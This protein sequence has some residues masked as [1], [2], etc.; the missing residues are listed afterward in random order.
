[1]TRGWKASTWEALSQE[2]AASLKWTW[3]P[4]MWH[5]SALPTADKRRSVISAPATDD[6]RP[7]EALFPF[8]EMASNVVDPALEFGA[9]QTERSDQDFKQRFQQG[10][11]DSFYGQGAFY[12]P[13]PPQTQNGSQP[14]ADSADAALQAIATAAQDRRPSTPSSAS[15]GAADANAH[16]CVLALLTLVLP[17]FC[18]LRVL[19]PAEAS[20][21]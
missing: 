12:G 15:V 11:Q 2:N 9:Q 16:G 10:L 3:H 6:S 4:G 21:Y 13:Y 18:F 5:L 7:P 17:V 19:I 8:G 1:M 14:A 20:C